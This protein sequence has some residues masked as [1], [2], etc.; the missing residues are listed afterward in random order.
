MASVRV[1]HRPVHTVAAGDEE[2]VTSEEDAAW[3][4]AAY[5]GPR[6][7]CLTPTARH[8]GRANVRCLSSLRDFG[9]GGSRGDIVD[10]E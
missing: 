4:H 3:G 8:Y 6:N 10:R 2:Y 5:S 1:C 9:E 7:G